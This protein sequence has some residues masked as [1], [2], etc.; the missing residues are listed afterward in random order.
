MLCN[1]KGENNI[2]VAN[3]ILFQSEKKVNPFKKCFRNLLIEIL[4]NIFL[5]IHYTFYLPISSISSELK[6]FIFYILYTSQVYS[7]LFL[8]ECHYYINVA[9]NYFKKFFI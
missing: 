9:K 3:L 1:G 6:S 5:L 7:K 4:K 8:C 2:I